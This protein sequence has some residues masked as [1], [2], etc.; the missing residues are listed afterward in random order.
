MKLSIYIKY[1]VFLAIIANAVGFIFPS[2]RST[3]SP[4]YGSIAKHILTSSNWS[5]LILLNQDWLDKPHLPF[6]LTAISFY[7]FGTNSIA[8]ILPGFLFHLIGLYFTYKLAKIWYSKEVA[9]LSVLLS[10]IDVRAEAFMLGEIMP[11]CY[12]W[13]RYDK[14][15]KLKYLLGGAV[16][17]AMAL[18]TKGLFSLITITSG[19]AVLWLYQ[20]RWRNFISFKWLFALALSFIFIFPELYVLYLQFDL[21]PEKIIYDHNGVSGIRWFFWDSQFGRFL[22]TGP[23]RNEHANFSHYFFFAYTFLWAYLPWWP[24]FFISVWRFIKN[25]TKNNIDKEAQIFLF[26]SF[27]LTF[28]LF[29]V[30]SFQVLL[31]LSVLHGFLM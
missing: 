20:G 1:L 25:F 6:W 14:T 23:I 30:S 29:S 28:I 8:Y 12:F 18:M 7:I 2:L 24:I 22:A 4:Y 19:I 21:H 10:A 13:L 15:N 9:L 3:F 17:T 26:A 16:F 5:D 31:V 27:F 11:A